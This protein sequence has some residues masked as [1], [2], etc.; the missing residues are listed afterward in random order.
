MKKMVIAG[1]SGFLGQALAEHFKTQFQ[2]IIILTRGISSKR[3]QLNYLSWNA[4]TPGDWCSILEGADVVLNLCGKS[5]D[6]RYNQKN[7]AE[8]LSSRLDSTRVI[9]E[10]IS[11]CKNPPSLW[12][13]GASATIYRHSLTTPMTERT[14]EYGSGFSVE[15]CKAWEQVFNSFVLPQTRR[16]NLRISMVLGNSGGVLPVMAG[17]V[18]KGLGGTMGKGDQLVSWLHIKDFCRVVEWLI[19]T[20]EASGAYNAVA[21]APVSN[22]KLMELIRKRSAMPFGLPVPAILLE[23]GAF[24]MRTETEL[25][26]KSRYAIPERLLEEGFRFNYPHIESCL[27]DLIP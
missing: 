8:I 20:P 3:G 7:K 12:I 24:F 16:A 15:V 27:E 6:C 5:V 26:L 9:G 14:G 19:H 4:E 1:G 23:A 11:A 18:K 22:K 21:E 25:V 13:N 10:A 2:D 17:L